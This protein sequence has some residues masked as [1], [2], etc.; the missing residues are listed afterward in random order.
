MINNLGSI[1][2]SLQAY[3]Q[4]IKSLP[5]NDTSDIFGLHANANI[6]FAQ[7]EAYTLLNAL[8]LLQPKTSSAGTMT[9]EEVVEDMATAIEEAIPEEINLEYVVKQYPVMYEQSMNT[10]LAQEIMRYN[11]LLRVISSSLN[12]LFKALRGQVIM[13]EDLELMADSIFNN[14]VPAKWAA[15]A[16]PSLK[17]LSS[18]VTDLT[19]RI[20]FIL[21]W[22]EK[23]I[24]PVGSLCS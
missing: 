11:R 21:N 10:V 4:Y 13:S 24:P 18:W 8:L 20:G 23:G 3:L 7:N 15:K 12:D 22:I 17:P 9:R 1:I 6:T 16:Y 5:L 19:D 14:Q 2:L